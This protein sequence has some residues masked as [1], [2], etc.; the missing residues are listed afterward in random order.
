[1]LEMQ[2]ATIG[3]KMEAS[4]RQNGKT[5]QILNLY[6]SFGMQNNYL[7]IIRDCQELKEVY[8][9]RIKLSDQDLAFLAKKISPKVE[10]IDLSYSFVM[11]YHVEIILKTC[12]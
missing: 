2:Y 7:Y 1:M 11:D 5:L 8:F 10:I 4:I 9:G 12:S 6:Y 3:P